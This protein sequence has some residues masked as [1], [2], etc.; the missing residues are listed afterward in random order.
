M[1]AFT[2]RVVFSSL[3]AAAL[4]SPAHAQFFNPCCPPPACCPKPVQACFQTVPVTEYRDVKQTVQ[5]PVEKTAYVDQQVTE[6]KQVVEQKTAQVPTVTY[7]QVVEN[8][9]VQRDCGQWVTQYQCRPKM[10]ACEYDSR[11]N[12][13]GWFNRVGYNARMALTPDT[14]AQRTYVPNVITENVPVTRM[15]A[16]PSTRTVNYSVAKLVPITSTRKVAVRTVEMVSQ[17]VTV[18]QPVTVMKT[19]PVGTAYAFGS[20]YG[21]PTT[22]TALSPTADPISATR[23]ADSRTNPIRPSTGGGT[24][25]PGPSSALPPRPIN[26]YDPNS[27]SIRI[28]PRTTARPVYDDVVVVSNRTHD[29]AKKSPPSAVTLG[30]WVA[31]KSTKNLGP[32]LPDAPGS[33]IISLAE[34]QRSRR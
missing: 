9:Q 13:F 28:E 16:V 20:F 34:N 21:Y 24:G 30:R 3:L 18:K 32:N 1:D 14:I 19:V 5:R 26:D 23:S 27:E 4:T 17:E 6:Y 11:Q 7:Q 8:R 10:T 29:S 31:R 25:T 2:S 15:V 22:T 33:A 12:L